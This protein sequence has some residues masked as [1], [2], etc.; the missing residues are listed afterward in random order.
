M[1]DD[2]GSGSLLAAAAAET[3]LSDE[4]IISNAAVLLFGGIETTEGMIANAA[5]HLLTHADVLS[6][7]YEQPSCSPRPSRSRCD[8]NPRPP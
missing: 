4:Q 7:V 8:S 2:A 3:D 6:R 1:D 5:L